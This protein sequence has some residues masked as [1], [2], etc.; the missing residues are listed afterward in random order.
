[1]SVDPNNHVLAETTFTG[2]HL[3][4]LEG[5]TIP[6]AC[7]RTWGQGRIFYSAVAHDLDD[8]Q[9]PDVTRLCTQG[10]AWAAR[11]NA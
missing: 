7:T 9:N 3:P 6:Q 2:E 11:Q 4:W 1:M 10:F 8:L 5:R